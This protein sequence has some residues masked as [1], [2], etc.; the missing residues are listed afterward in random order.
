LH[1]EGLGKDDLEEGKIRTEMRGLLFWVNLARKDKNVEPTAQVVQRADLPVRQDG[2]AIVRTLVGEGSPITLGTPGLILDVEL[3]KG[4][5]VSLAPTEAGRAVHRSPFL[6]RVARSPWRTGN[7]ERG[8][9]SW[10]GSRTARLRS[11]TG[12][13][14]TD[15]A[16]LRYL[17][18]G[19]LRRPEF[20]FLC[21]QLAR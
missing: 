3:P 21:G 8:S 16:D 15:R 20:F 12:R 9:C 13:T 17:T 18:P 11:S 19:A 6:D 10:P 7:R 5:S 2:D 1:A 4:G 14:S